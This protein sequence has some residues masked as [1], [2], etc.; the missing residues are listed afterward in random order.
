MAY[1][2]SLVGVERVLYP[3]DER[4]QI[5][6]RRLR[7]AG[8]RHQMS[9]QLAKRLL[10]DLRVIR[11][12]LEVQAVQREAA[13]LRAAVVA[14]DAVGIQH[15]LMGLML[16]WLGRCSGLCECRRGDQNQNSTCVKQ[17]LHRCRDSALEGK[18]T[19]RSTRG[20]GKGRLFLRLVCFLWF[21]PLDYG[22]IPS[23]ISILVP[24]GSVMNATR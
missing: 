21:L 5:L 8:R 6:L 19:T 9:A 14:R 17:T 12:G 2:R 13:D 7:T 24:Q 1:P 18:G 20:A 16:I 4:I 11:C 23:V 15:C 10:P 3:T 22:A